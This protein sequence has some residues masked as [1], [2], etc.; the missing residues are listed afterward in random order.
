MRVKTIGLLA[1]LVLIVCKRS[2]PR[3]RKNFVH[4]PDTGSF[5]S[6]FLPQP[7]DEGLCRR[8]RPGGTRRAKRRKCR[9]EVEVGRRRSGKRS[10]RAEAAR[11]ELKRL[12]SASSAN[13]LERAAHGEAEEATRRTRQ[14]PRCL[15]GS[16]PPSAAYLARET[17]KRSVVEFRAAALSP[18][19][20]RHDRR[21]GRCAGAAVG[22]E[23]RRRYLHPARP[24]QSLDFEVSP[25]GKGVRHPSFPPRRRRSF[26]DGF[27]RGG[28]ADQ[29][30]ER[31]HVLLVAAFFGFALLRH[32]CALL[33]RRRALLLP[34]FV[35]GADHRGHT[36]TATTT[37]AAA[38]AEAT[39]RLAIAKALM[40]VLSGDGRQYPRRR[41]SRE[42]RERRLRQG[43]NGAVTFIAR[44]RPRGG[45]RG[46]AQDDPQAAKRLNSRLRF[47]RTGATSGRA[48]RTSA[49]EPPRF[50]RSH[51]LRVT[52][53]VRECRRKFSTMEKCEN[54]M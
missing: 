2:L 43:E 14:R 47:R 46:G 20:V 40:S 17:E 51:G 31:R 35:V 4:G 22:R 45:S 21:S 37:A 42:T 38:L 5:A 44:L 6:R 54:I 9:A 32:G 34:A 49:I 39:E 13:E 48:R 23:R 50:V 10:A 8:Q 41:S 15:P 11:N 53:S 30:L 24:R 25:T 26:G 27:R 52:E 7:T 16:R 19:P 1:N 18:A 12:K 29:R 36:P 28:L 3:G 33:L